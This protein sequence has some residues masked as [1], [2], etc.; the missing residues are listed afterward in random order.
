M[1]SAGGNAVKWCSI[2]T[3]ASSCGVSRATQMLPRQLAAGID[4]VQPAAEAP[5]GV[6]LRLTSAMEPHPIP[7][8]KLGAMAS[9]RP[10]SRRSEPIRRGMLEPKGTVSAGQAD[11]APCLSPHL[12]AQRHGEH[13][14]G[15]GHDVALQS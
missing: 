12:L 5:T 4:V 11:V 13:R 2:P 14:G 6:Q 10:S 1:R 9:R 7:L 3:T 15:Y 8:S